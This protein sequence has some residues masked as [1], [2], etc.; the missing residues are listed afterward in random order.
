MKVERL[1]SDRG[2]FYQ[3]FAEIDNPHV[4]LHDPVYLKRGCYFV[5]D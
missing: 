3:V 4:T 5:A 2:L 1:Q